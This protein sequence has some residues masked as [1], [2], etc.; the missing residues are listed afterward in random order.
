MEQWILAE[1]GGDRLIVWNGAG[2][3]HGKEGQTIPRNNEVYYI[4]KPMW[5][6]LCKETYN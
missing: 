3:I 6:D 4:D 2:A 1:V 5:S